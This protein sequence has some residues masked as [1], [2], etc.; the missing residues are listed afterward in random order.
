MKKKM[1]IKLHVDSL[2]I[3]L[4]IFEALVFYSHRISKKKKKHSHGLTYT[5]L[6]HAGIDRCFYFSKIW[7]LLLVIEVYV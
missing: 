1:R 2:S 3:K 4:N 6:T 7:S 5:S